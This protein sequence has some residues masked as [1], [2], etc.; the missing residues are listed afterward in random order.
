[1]KFSATKV[2]W[3]LE[4]QD[5]SQRW[6]AERAGLHKN[7]ISLL[8]SN[9][10][11]TDKIMLYTINHIAKALGVEATDVV[12]DGHPTQRQEVQP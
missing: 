2:K 5:R 7:T 6:L 1:M 10:E 4:E 3:L 12:I 8:L 11:P 9:D